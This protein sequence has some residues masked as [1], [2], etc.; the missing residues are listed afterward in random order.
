MKYGSNN[1]LLLLTCVHVYFIINFKLKI[2]SKL[3]K[4]LQKQEKAF[5]T[6]DYRMLNA[7]KA[8]KYF[9]SIQGSNTHYCTP[10]QSLPVDIYSSME[11]AIINR[12]GSMVSINRSKLF[13]QFERYNELAERADSLNSKVTIYGYVSVDLL[14]DLYCFLNGR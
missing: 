6:E 3:I 14:N 4:E 7:V 12:K 13:R 9:L 10:R 11:L 5:S 8:G 2:M 1:F